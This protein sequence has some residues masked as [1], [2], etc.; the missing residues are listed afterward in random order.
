MI[1]RVVLDKEP[2]NGLLLVFNGV[3]CYFATGERCEVLRSACLYVCLFIC[4]CVRSYISTTTCPNITNFYTCYL[5]PWLGPPPMT[6]QYVMYF[7][8]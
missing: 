1:I 2:L 8:F 6:V 7:R 3:G 5:W 4:L